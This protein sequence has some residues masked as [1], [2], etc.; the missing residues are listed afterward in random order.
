MAKRPLKMPALPPGDRLTFFRSMQD[1]VLRNGDLSVK[2]LSLRISGYSHQAVYKAITGPKVPSRQITEAIVHALE[3]EQGVKW[4]SELWCKAVSEQRSEQ[5]AGQA[6]DVPR[7]GGS[8]SDVVATELIGRRAQDRVG[9]AE[10]PSGRDTA[11][12]AREGTAP[13]RY[14][15]DKTSLS[16]RS[17]SDRPG[18]VLSS[19]H[20]ARTSGDQSAALLEPEVGSAP[21]IRLSPR[22]AEALRAWME[23]ENKT[24]AA[25]K[26][27]IS[28]GT[29][30]T[31]LY[32]IRQKYAQLGRP[33]AS[34]AAL[35]AQAL[36]DGYVQ[37]NDVAGESK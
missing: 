21:T 7:D 13:R 9:G 27:F 19:V 15:H 26:L 37:I 34:K 6:N 22:E 14:T 1:L 4:V 8:P 29:L 18:A 31:Y 25:K 20:A 17:L 28:V 16:P 24:E 5:H 11:T 3:G 30:N 35:L 23:C 10:A 33:S 36:Q 32:R 2:D 12:A